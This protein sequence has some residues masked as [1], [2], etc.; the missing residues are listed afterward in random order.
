MQHTHVGLYIKSLI[1]EKMAISEAAEKLGITRFALARALSRTR[2]S[3]SFKAK[4]TE[5]LGITIHDISYNRD[6]AQ[7]RTIL[8]EYITKQG[9][10]WV[11]LARKLGIESALLHYYL[12]KATISS[13]FVQIVKEKLDI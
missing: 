4:L 5:R 8:R 3:E 9:I 12:D 1:K 7:H 6:E 2:V 10:L 11:D 13:K